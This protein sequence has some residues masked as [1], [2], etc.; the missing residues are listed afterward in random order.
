MLSLALQSAH[1]ITCKSK[2]GYQMP[3]APIAYQIRLILRKPIR[4]VGYTNSQSCRTEQIYEDP[5]SGRPKDMRWFNG[6]VECADL[7][8]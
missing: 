8:F 1:H 4:K 2:V 5:S 7:S 3:F 6:K